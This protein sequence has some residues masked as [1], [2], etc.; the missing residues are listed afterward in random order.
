MTTEEKQLRALIAAGLESAE[1]HCKLGETLRIQKRFPEALR[2][3]ERALTMG[4]DSADAAFGTGCTLLELEREAAAIPYLERTAAILPNHYGVLHNLAKAQYAVGLVDEAAAN[5][6]A[7]EAARGGPLHRSSLAVVIPGAPSAT[8]ADVLAARQAYA[9]NDLPRPFSPL[10]GERPS[11]PLRIGYLSSFFHAPHWM[12]PVWAIINRHDRDD[13]VVHLISDATL[14]ECEASGYKND[15]RDKFVSIRG[16]DNHRAAVRT[17]DLNLDLLI[18]LN[19]YS[20]PQRLEILAYRPA[21]TVAA[22]FN[23]YATSGMRC[24]DYLI[25]DPVVIRPDEEAYYTEK[26]ARVSTTYLTYEVTY[27]VPPVAEAPASANGFVT[28]GCFASQY[29]LTPQVISA[30]CAIL[31]GAPRSKLLIKNGTMAVDS[32]RAALLSRFTANGI[33]PARIDFEP[34]APHFDYLAAYD[35]IDIALDPYPYNGGTTTSEALWQ[36]VPVLCFD[37]DRWASRQGASLLRAAGLDAF[38]ARDEADY[39]AR[40]I[41]FGNNGVPNE[42]QTMRERLAASKMM[43]TAGFAREMESIYRR[44]VRMED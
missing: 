2:S 23:Q 41:A 16:L 28:F 24:Y 35:K 13:F 6:R 37:G 9:E 30:W 20:R 18:D 22:W 21:R 11:G 33:D 44:L 5:F 4:D 1:V 14:E 17:A 36:G 42:R 39:I 27:P 25:G 3:F 40:A 32:N 29:K 31:N 7:A 34:G 15:A 12:K 10:P 43:D 19:S 38:V 8:H 26:I